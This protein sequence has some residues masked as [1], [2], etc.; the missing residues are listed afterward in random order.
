MENIEGMVLVIL[1]MWLFFTARRQT[2]FQ[3]RLMAARQS[4]TKKTRR[5]WELIH[6]SADDTQGYANLTSSLQQ[7][8][9]GLN[10]YM[11]HCHKAYNEL[12][13]QYYALKCIF[14]NFQISQFL[15]SR[16][17]RPS[18]WTFNRPSEWWDVIVPVIVQWV[19]NFRMS[20]GPFTYLCNKLRAA[21]ERQ[22]TNFHM[23]VHLKKRVAIALWKLVT[24]SEYKVELSMSLLGTSTEVVLKKSTR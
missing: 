2:L 1:G 6:Q 3:K 18:V 8:V 9:Q 12:S 21:M 5:V 19:E 11:Y 4:T 10:W 13:C 17:H 22:D 14:C 7:C 15:Q 20:E 23:C 24:G 16:R